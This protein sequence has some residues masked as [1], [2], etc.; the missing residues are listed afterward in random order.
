MINNIKCSEFIESNHYNR[1]RKKEI[2][3]LLFLLQNG[4][5]LEMS[6]ST[7]NIHDINLVDDIMNI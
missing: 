3:Y 6:L 2:K 1:G 7:S 5:S 4:V